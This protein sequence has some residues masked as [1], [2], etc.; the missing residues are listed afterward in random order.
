M[1]LLTLAITPGDP[2]GIGPEIVWKTFCKNPRL[3]Q[4]ANLV[5]IGASQPFKKLGAKIILLPLEKELWP[6][7]FKD[8][9]N[10]F[11]C[12]FILPAPT[13][14]KARCL[15]GFQAG[16][17]IQTA[18]E[19]ALDHTV[20]A[21]VTGPIHKDR[22][23][24]GGFRFPGHTEFLAS[25]CK[26]KSPVSPIMMLANS[27]LKVTLVTTHHALKDV[28][29]VLSQKKII[30]TVQGTVL[31]LRE[32]WKISRPRI[33]VCSLNPHAGENGRFGNEEKKILAPALKKA[34]LLLNHSALIQG[35][36]P[37]DTLFAKECLLPKHKRVDAIV[38]MYHDQGLIPIKLLDFPNTVNITLGL[39]IIR[40]SVDHGVGFDIAGLGKADPSSFWAALKYAIRLAKTFRD[41]KV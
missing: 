5:C 2:D 20:A 11:P 25:L 19:L 35:P 8:H 37:A 23:N 4:K 36:F 34:A 41:R 32:S 29:R 31:A 14:S 28:A 10:D 38:C 3:N 12:I 33:A 15:P 17:S 9:K 6:G 22:L 27:K 13:R 7:F 26:I 1:P 40:T 39:P 24:R 21:L 30:D 16:W 18:A